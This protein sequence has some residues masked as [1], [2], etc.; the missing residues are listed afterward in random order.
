LIEFEIE[1]P[2]GNIGYLS[3]NR[4]VV[5][6][7]LSLPNPDI[8]R[9]FGWSSSSH[10]CPPWVWAVGKPFCRSFES[11]I[12]SKRTPFAHERFAILR[13]DRGFRR[14]HTAR[15]NRVV[16]SQAELLLCYL[17]DRTFSTPLSS[18]AE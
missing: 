10:K 9:T 6:I 17:N 4:R 13:A 12:D 3:V 1:S 14:F 7:A 11:K 16:S 2:S 5:F 8:R 15:V 18:S